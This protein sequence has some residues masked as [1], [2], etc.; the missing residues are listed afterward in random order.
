MTSNTL[1]VDN[2][3]PQLSSRLCERARIEFAEK[4]YQQLWE[5]TE[6]Y[7][8]NCYIVDKSLINNNAYEEI[9]PMVSAY[10]KE[11]SEDSANELISRIFAASFYFKNLTLR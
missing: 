1:S 2:A 9:R 3:I 4:R 7:F 8:Y 5:T 6:Q 10:Q 11:I